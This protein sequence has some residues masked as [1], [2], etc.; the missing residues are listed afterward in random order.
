MS[1]KWYLV[2]KLVPTHITTVG[3]AK[4]VED[5]RKHEKVQRQHVEDQRQQVEDLRQ[6][7]KGQRQQVEDQRQQVRALTTQ[8]DQCKQKKPSKPR[9]S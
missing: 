9:E 3:T 4:L 2:P 8:L 7:V 5:L 1:S 6:Q